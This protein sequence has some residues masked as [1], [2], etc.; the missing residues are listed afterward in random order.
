MILETHAVPVAPE[1]AYL[2]LDLEED[3]DL[4]FSHI[5]MTGFELDRFEWLRR[6]CERLEDEAFLFGTVQK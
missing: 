6:E 4:C 5:P 3:S 1:L 2:L